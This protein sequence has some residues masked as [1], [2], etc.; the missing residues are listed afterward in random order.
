MPFQAPAEGSVHGHLEIEVLPTLKLIVTVPP[1]KRLDRPVAVCTA[2]ASIVFMPPVRTQG[3]PF[4]HWKVDIE[5]AEAA[6]ASR[7][8]RQKYVTSAMTTMASTISAAPENGS[9]T[10]EGLVSTFHHY[11]PPTVPTTGQV[12]F[13]LPQPYVQLSSFQAPWQAPLTLLPFQPPLAPPLSPSPQSLPSPL[14]PIPSPSPI[15]P[16]SPILLPYESPPSPILSPS[17]SWPILPPPPPSSPYR[18]MWQD[19]ETT[20]ARLGS[21]AI[22]QWAPEPALGSEFDLEELIA[23]LNLVWDGQNQTFWEQFTQ[24]VVEE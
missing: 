24:D 19:P 23:K 5:R 2:L 18:T 7:Q 6:K 20:P 22:W 21:A 10:L 8:Q 17:P 12:S 13:P 11:V 1:A 15:L 9:H 3:D 14:S 16:P 4:V